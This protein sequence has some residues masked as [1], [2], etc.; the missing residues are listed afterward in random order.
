M[1]RQTDIQPEGDCRIERK[2]ERRDNRYSEGDGK[3]YSL[4]AEK[5]HKLGW[6]GRV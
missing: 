1:D 5:T 6:L 2:K 4:V 3:V